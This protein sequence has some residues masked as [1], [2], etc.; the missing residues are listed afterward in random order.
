MPASF[1]NGAV[2]Q[3]IPCLIDTSIM[4]VRKGLSDDVAYKLTKSLVEGYEEL[5]LIQPTWNTLKPETMTLN[6]P[7]ALHPGAEKYYREAGLL[8]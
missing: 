3:D 1:Y 8:K 6:L 4:I 2:G 5:G 7:I